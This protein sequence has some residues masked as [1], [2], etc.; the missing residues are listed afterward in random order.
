VLLK[1]GSDPVRLYQQG[2]AVEAQQCLSDLRGY[3]DEENDKDVHKVVSA[4]LDRVNQLVGLLLQ[5]RL[6]TRGPVE[7]PQTSLRFVDKR[8]MPDDPDQIADTMGLRKG[9]A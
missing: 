3:T 6:T 9:E 7:A 1:D 5:H 2:K 4:A 8:V